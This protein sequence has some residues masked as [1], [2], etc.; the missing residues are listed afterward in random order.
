MEKEEESRERVSATIPVPSYHNP[1]WQTSPFSSKLNEGRGRRGQR[2]GKQR[3][4]AAPS[5]ISFHRINP[6]LTTPALATDAKG[7]SFPS[8][9]FALGETRRRGTSCESPTAMVHEATVAAAYAAVGRGRVGVRREEG[10][11]RGEMSV[12]ES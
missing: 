6:M 11:Q 3:K 9:A 10:I 2:G 5:L 8:S 7:M 1:L 4:I 12:E